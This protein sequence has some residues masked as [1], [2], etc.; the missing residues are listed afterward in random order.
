[1]SPG[2]DLTVVRGERRNRMKVF[3]APSVVVSSVVCS[4]PKSL[5]SSTS[6]DLSNHVESRSRSLLACNIVKLWVEVLIH[7]LGIA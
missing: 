7:N 5:H 1:M 2:H 6:P 4:S 3:V